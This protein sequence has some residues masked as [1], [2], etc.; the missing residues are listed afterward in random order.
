MQNNTNKNKFL[1]IVSYTLPDTSGT[2]IN[3]MNFAKYIKDKGKSIE[4]LTFNRNLKLPNKELFDHVP[5]YRVTYFNKTILHKLFSL[6]LIIPYYTFFIFKNNVIFI[7]GGKIIG[8]E[9]AILIGL[10]FRKKLVFQSQLKKV[11][12]VKTII[13]NKPCYIRPFYRF[14][15]KFINIYYSL[16]ADFSVQYRDILRNNSKIF[17]LSQGVN[18]SIFPLVNENEKIKLRN[19]LDLSLKSFII[20]SIGFL[21]KR[22]GFEEIFRQLVKIKLPFLYII[23]GEYNIS[24]NHF[25]SNKKEEMHFLYNVGNSILGDKL[26]FVGHHTDIYEYIQAADIFLQ[27]SYQEGLP[28]SLLEAMSCGIP[29]VVRNL[30]GINDFITIH[31][32]NSMVFENMDQMTEQITKLYSDKN[33]RNNLGK[34]AYSFIHENCSFDIVFKKLKESINT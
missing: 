9:F 26:K 12:D 5:V 24:D 18:T 22:K 34:N 6:I 13:Y 11:D 30:S 28:N 19:K 16:N 27:N 8:Y 20:L 7:Y 33:L 31:N 2:G 15:L 25:L 29:P 14:L 32:K 10:L 21:I 3:A 1:F 23:A 17:E 4:L